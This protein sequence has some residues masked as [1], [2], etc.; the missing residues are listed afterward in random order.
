MYHTFQEN[1]KLKARREYLKNGVCMLKEVLCNM[2]TSVESAKICEQFYAQT[3]RHG[4]LPK[5]VQRQP[6]SHGHAQTGA[7]EVSSCQNLTQFSGGHIITSVGSLGQGQVVGGPV[8]FVPMEVTAQPVDESYQEA[9]TSMIY[10]TTSSPPSF[11]G[12]YHRPQ[13]EAAVFASAQPQV[14]TQSPQPPVYMHSPQSAGFSPQSVPSSSPA[15]SP[16]AYCSAAGT[17]QFSPFAVTV[18][19]GQE[20]Y[21]S[22]QPGQEA[23]P[24]EQYFHV[25]DDILQGTDPVEEVIDSS[26]T[27]MADAFVPPILEKQMS[28]SSIRVTSLDSII[29]SSQGLIRDQ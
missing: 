13:Q 28:G 14:V 12:C 6:R 24:N 19:P 29:F 8:A 5:T 26:G 1:E 21:S 10:V 20:A 4:N 2:R 16:E 25:F 11:N 27:E 23:Y 15:S 3:R 22:E 18:Q 7:T 9:E 17:A